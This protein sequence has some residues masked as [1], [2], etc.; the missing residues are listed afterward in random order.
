MEKN[1]LLRRIPK[2]DDLLRSERL[3]GLDL[4]RPVLTGLVRDALE[5]LRGGILSG[6]LERLPEEDALCDSIRRSARAAA[7]PSLR[8]VINATGIPLHTN[9]G[10]ACLSE[11]A[12]AAAMAA[13][14]QYSTLEYD[15]ESGSRGS[16][17]CHV[18]GLLCRRSGGISQSLPGGRA[19]AGIASRIGEKG[20]GS[21]TALFQA[22]VMD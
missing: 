18:E 20:H 13:A 4:P 15:L 6:Q 1:E 8:P 17:H 16:R 5:D 12:A 21:A 10:R 22:K 9:L 11:R 19:A 14:T 7:R 3:S 2:V